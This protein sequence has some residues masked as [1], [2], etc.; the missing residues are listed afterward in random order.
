MPHR[1][2]EDHGGLAT[3]IDILDK[4]IAHTM[5]KGHQPGLA[6]GIVYDGDLLWGKGYGH[7]DTAGVYGS[8]AVHNLPNAH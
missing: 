1:L 5:H 6:I 2:V 7:A 4:W 3:S 8:N